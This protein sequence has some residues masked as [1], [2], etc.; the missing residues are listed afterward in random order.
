MRRQK[1]AWR[2][3]LSRS[4]RRRIGGGQAAHSAVSRDQS[5]EPQQVLGHNI[6]SPVPAF[7]EAQRLYTC[8]LD[9]RNLLPGRCSNKKAERR[10]A[11]QC[12]R[13]PRG[14]VG[15]LCRPGNST[16]DRIPIGPVAA[17]NARFTTCLAATDQARVLV[18]RRRLRHPGRCRAPSQRKARNH[19]RGVM[20]A[21]RLI[22]GKTALTGGADPAFSGHAALRKRRGRAHCS[23][24]RGKLTRAKSP[25]IRR[26]TAS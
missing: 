19:R 20:V 11:Q 14:G 13:H 18:D 25:Y 23:F 22:G 4:F 6:A 2:D 17:A 8:S 5:R 9:R 24:L 1:S 21:M 7:G 10:T 16:C 3:A 26:A 15:N 12:E